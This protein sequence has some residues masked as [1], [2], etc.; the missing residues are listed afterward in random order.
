MASTRQSTKKRDANQI[1][2]S[3]KPHEDEGVAKARTVLRPNVQAAITLTNNGTETDYGQSLLDRCDA[4]CFPA[5]WIRF[6]NGDGEST[7]SPLQGQ[8]ICYFGSDRDRFRQCFQFRGRVLYD[9][10]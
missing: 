3:T 6:I 4:T 10:H 7:G 8:M 9:A 5:K 1:I 2:A